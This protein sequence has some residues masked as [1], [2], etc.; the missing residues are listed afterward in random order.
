[1]ANITDKKYD[2]GEIMAEDY[3]LRYYEIL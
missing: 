1:M 2:L 3:Y